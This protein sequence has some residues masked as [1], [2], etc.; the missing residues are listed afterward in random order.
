MTRLEWAV[1]P[2]RSLL[3][4]QQQS[5]HLTSTS[6][7]NLRPS[8]DN[9]ALRSTNNSSRYVII[10]VIKMILNNWANTRQKKTKCE[11][12]H[13]CYVAKK[14]RSMKKVLLVKA[15]TKPILR[16][17]KLSDNNRIDGMFLWRQT[18]M[19]NKKS[20]NYERKLEWEREK[21]E[22]RNLFSPW[23]VLNLNLSDFCHFTPDHRTCCVIVSIF[24]CEKLYC[25]LARC[26]SFN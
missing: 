22:I 8:I 13:K 2:S 16:Y 14:W 17:R 6:S 21:L 9:I 4:S 5:C 1:L 24:N 18:I 3:T 25:V 19:E 12:S 7:D 15:R 10:G 23:N 20:T 11:K 26:T